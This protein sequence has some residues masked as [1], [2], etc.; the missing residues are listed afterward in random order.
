MALPFAGY[1]AAILRRLDRA[2]RARKR[3]LNYWL[4]RNLNGGAVRVPFLTPMRFPH[5][6]SVTTAKKSWRR[7][8]SQY[9][10]HRQRRQTHA[11]IATL[12]ALR[13]GVRAKSVERL[14][15]DRSLLESRDTRHGCRAEP[16]AGHGSVAPPAVHRRRHSRHRHLCAHRPGRQPGGRRRLAAVPCRLRRGADHCAELSRTRHKVSEGRRRRALHPQGV[17]HPSYHLQRCV[18][19]DVLGDYFRFHCL[20]SFL[21]QHVERAW[22]RLVGV[23]HHH[24]GSRLHGGRARLASACRGS[25][26]P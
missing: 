15:D 2:F 4:R 21:C 17:R 6:R 16:A 8:E 13:P 9:A 24:D 23:R 11:C 7:H 10:A 22:P 1:G 5:R 14:R 18:C 26:S 12:S 3:I 20:A 19:S 25:A